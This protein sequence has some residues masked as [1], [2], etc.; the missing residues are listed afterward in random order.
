MSMQLRDYEEK[1]L[2]S[3]FPK[4]FCGHRLKDLE[5]IGKREGRGALIILAGGVILCFGC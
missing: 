3:I 4:S 1:K 5:N 2:S